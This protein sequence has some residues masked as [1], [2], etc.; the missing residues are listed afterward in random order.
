MIIFSPLGKLLGRE[1]DAA[2][3]PEPS[4]E[5][6]TEELIK[7]QKEQNDKDEQGRRRST[8]RSNSKV[9]LANAPREEAIH[10]AYPLIQ[11]FSSSVFGCRQAPATIQGASIAF[12]AV[13]QRQSRNIGT[14]TAQSQLS[15]LK[16]ISQA[17]KRRPVSAYSYLVYL[18]ILKGT[19][20]ALELIDINL[21]LHVY[22]QYKMVYI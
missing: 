3:F 11:E 12:F 22:S 7:F 20:I 17:R 13:G 1:V 10:A 2:D 18:Y 6:T 8:G 9:A 14:Q 16:P 5:L 21:S 19:G 4:D 15:P